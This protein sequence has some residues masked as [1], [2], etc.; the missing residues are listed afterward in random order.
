THIYEL[1]TKND[2]LSTAINKPSGYPPH[3]PL[4]DSI[5]TTHKDTSSTQQPDTSK[6]HHNRITSSAV[7]TPDSTAALDKTLKNKKVQPPDSSS[8]TDTTKSNPKVPLSNI[9]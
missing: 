5:K 8:I 1:W 4:P 9:K 7:R 3:T 6:V 2:S